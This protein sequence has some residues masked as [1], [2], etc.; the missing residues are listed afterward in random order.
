MTKN[1]VKKNFTNIFYHSRKKKK[2]Y[3]ASSSDESS[4]SS[5]STESKT[6]LSA[7]KAGH[8]KCKCPYSSDHHVSKHKKVKHPPPVE[9]SS[10]ENSDSSESEINEESF[11]LSSD[12]ESPKGKHKDKHTLKHKMDITE[13]SKSGKH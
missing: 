7:H 13:M 4:S 9:S 8:K 2:K 6:P 10:L 1:L 5:S 12:D 3:V 11:S